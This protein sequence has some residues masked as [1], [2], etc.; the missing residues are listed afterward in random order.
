MTGPPAVTAATKPLGMS[1]PSGEPRLFEVR[2]PDGRRFD[3]RRQVNEHQAQLLLSSGICD[4]VRSAT[5][6]LRYLRL[7]HNAPVSRF[8]SILAED[9]VTT[10]KTAEWTFEHRFSTPRHPWPAPP[11]K[12][13]STKT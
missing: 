10:S 13:A 4:A 3:S 12:V 5:G 8:A 11:E 1:R 9:S 6:I 7:R 2:W